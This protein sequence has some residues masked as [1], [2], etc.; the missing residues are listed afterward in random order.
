MASDSGG[1]SAADKTRPKVSQLTISPSSFTAA[2]S[3]PALIAAVGG[4]VYYR[5]SEPAK[6]TFTVERPVKGRKKG[7]KCT[8]GRKKG[9]RCTTYKKVKGSFTHRGSAGLNSFRFM[10]RLRGKPLKK[11]SYRLRSVATDAAG[12]KSKPVYRKFRIKR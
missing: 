8:A 2:N 6:T 11:G 4:R 7:R 1:G 9:K 10:G 12:N 3:G 5:L